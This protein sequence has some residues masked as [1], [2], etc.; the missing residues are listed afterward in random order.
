MPPIEYTLKGAS[1]SPSVSTSAL[2]TRPVRGLA[3]SAQPIASRNGGITIGSAIITRAAPFIGRS[4]RSTI[5][6]S[7]PPTASAEIVH[8]AANTAVW[9]IRR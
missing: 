2:F 3:S 7:T 1:A 4:V 5:Q 8:P 9:P 6:A